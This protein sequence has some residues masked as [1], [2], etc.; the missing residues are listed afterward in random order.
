MELYSRRERERLYET[1]RRTVLSISA[2][3]RWK[4]MFRDVSGVITM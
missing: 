3:K 4:R 2:V 1:L